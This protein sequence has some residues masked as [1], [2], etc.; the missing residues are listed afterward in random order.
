MQTD[1][2]ESVQPAI[3]YDSWTCPKTGLILPMRLRENLAWRSALIGAASADKEFK[4]TILAACTQSPVLWLSAFAFTIRYFKVEGSHSVPVEHAD[5]P[6]I[7]WP[8]QIELVNEI[9]RCLEEGDSLLIQKSRDVGASW[10]CVAM[11]VHRFLFKKRQSFLL[12]SRKEAG[13]DNLSGNVSNYP[14]ENIGADYTLLGKVDYLLSKLPK[15]MLPNELHRKAMHLYCPSSQNRIDAESSNEA[16]GS[17]DRRTAILCDEFAK[18]ENAESIRRSTKDVTATRLIVSTA[19]GAGTEFSKWAQDGT[20][21]V[22]S[23]MWH[24][25]PEK[26][27]GLYSVKDDNGADK[28]RS[29][30]YDEE[31]KKRTPKEISIELDCNHQGSGDSIFDVNLIETHRRKF[32]KPPLRTMGIKWNTKLSD[33]GITRAISSLKLNELRTSPGGLYRIWTHLPEGR[34]DQTKTYILGMDISKGQGASNSVISVLCVETKEKVME[35]CNANITPSELAKEACGIALWIGG[36]NRRPLIIFENNGDAGFAFGRALVQT[37]KYP[38]IYFDR[39]V[40]TVSEPSG[41]RYG[42]RS[43]PEKKAQAIEALERAYSCGNYV[44]HSNESLD[45]CLQ[46][47]RFPNGSIGPSELLSENESARKVHGD[48]VIADMLTVWGAEFENVKF[49]KEMQSTRNPRSFAGRMA[50]WREE[51]KR[52]SSNGYPTFKWEKSVTE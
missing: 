3:M 8:K 2:K 12:I 50:V 14:N 10:L 24:H 37:F 44:N 5:Y 18:C 9:D 34:L 48:R 17:G 36:R 1:V 47:I 6:F 4:N 22:T 19:N 16:A 26:S 23:L 43:S 46:Y 31:C 21:K 27:V 51:K 25:S 11:F 29:P 41:K 42:W 28:I 45:E 7:P 30:W 20:I 49:R 52:E 39:R 32:A 15:W 13:C 33:E 35:Y 38:N 40:G